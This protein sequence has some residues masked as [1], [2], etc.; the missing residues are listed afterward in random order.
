VRSARWASDRRRLRP[1]RSRRSGTSSLDG[2][3]GRVEILSENSKLPRLS[4]RLLKKGTSHESMFT[5]NAHLSTPCKPY[6]R[7]ARARA[8]PLVALERGSLR[9]PPRGVLVPAG[10]VSR[11]YVPVT[12]RDPFTP[13]NARHARPYGSGRL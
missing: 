2:P 4:T 1:A 13:V 5:I 10:S 8:S 6:E 11:R 3:A 7:G 9:D 12:T